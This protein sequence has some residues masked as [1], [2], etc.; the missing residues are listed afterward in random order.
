MK[1]TLWVLLLAT[2]FF[3]AQAQEMT[4]KKKSKQAIADTVKDYKS[5]PYWI[6]MMDDTAA[7]YFEVCKAFNTYWEGKIKPVRE[8]NEAHN[9]FSDG[10]EDNEEILSSEYTY[11]YKRFKFWERYY[12]D[13]HDENGIIFSAD[14]IIDEWRKKT[15]AE[16]KEGAR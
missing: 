9:I 11:E 10:E 1:Q 4:P 7:N 12:R 16:R 8:D 2:A 14:R 13:L 15:E 5:Y 3:T 6:I